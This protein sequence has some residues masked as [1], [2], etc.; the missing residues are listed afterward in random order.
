MRKQ[1]WGILGAAGIARTQLIP[2]LHQSELC[3]IAAVASRDLAKASVYARDN[4]IPQ[5]YGLTRSCWPTLLSMS[6]TT[7][8]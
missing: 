1:R 8:A 3:E 4:A 7:A 2:A 6:S 5:A